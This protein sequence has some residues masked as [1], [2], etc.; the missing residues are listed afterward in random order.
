M[1]RNRPLSRWNKSNI[2]VSPRSS[3]TARKSFSRLGFSIVDEWVKAYRELDD[4]LMTLPAS[5][6]EN[7]M[8][9]THIIKEK[10]IRLEK[11]IEYVHPKIEGTDITM[12]D[13]LE[14]EESQPT[15]KGQKIDD[16]DTETLMRVLDATAETSP[17]PQDS[18]DSMEQ[19]G[20]VLEASQV[21]EGS[22]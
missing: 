8:L 16:I 20:T 10:L 4:E 1:A 2:P 18:P 12:T 15:M 13:L 11:I 14:A 6:L 5:N 3:A 17:K 21:P 9:R 22:L 7:K 19:G